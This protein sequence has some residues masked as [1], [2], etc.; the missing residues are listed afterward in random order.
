MKLCH[1]DGTSV[2]RTLDAFVDVT[3]GGLTTDGYNDF[4][5]L[6]PTSP[7][8]K[9]PTL[10]E[11]A[12]ANVQFYGRV[13]FTTGGRLALHKCAISLLRTLWRNGMRKYESTHITTHPLTIQQGI[14]QDYQEIKI[15]SPKEARRML[16]V[17]VAPDGNCDLQTK[18]LRSKSEQWS[19][20]I[21]NNRMATFEILMSY[22]QGLM[23]SLEFPLGA[24]LLTESQCK[25]IQA[26]ALTCCLQ[27]SGVLSTISRSV[28]F[29][30]KRFCGL[31]FSNL[32]T[33]AGIQK[34][35][36]LIGHIRKM[37][38]PGQIILVALACLQQEVGISTPV[39]SSSYKLYSCV[40]IPSWCN[41]VWKFLHDISGSIRYDSAWTPK[42]CFTNDTNIMEQIAQMDF[43][44]QQKYQINICRLY[45]RVYYLDE[46]M[47]SSGTNFRRDVFD[48]TKPGFHNDKFPL[49]CVPSSFTEL[50][51]SAILSIAKNRDLGTSLGLIQS[52]SSFEYCMDS[53]QQILFRFQRHKIISCHIRSA[54]ADAYHSSPSSLFFSPAPTRVAEVT[55]V[56]N[57]IHVLRS[58]EL[59]QHHI[60]PSPSINVSHPTFLQFQHYL[61]SMSSAHFRNIGLLS[62]RNWDTFLE[63]F[64]HSEIIA[65][66]D[67]SVK[68]KSGCHSY[69][70]ET[71]NELAH[72]HGRDPVDADP[73]DMTSTR[74]ERC[75]VLAILSITTA[76]A[77]LLQVQGI[78]MS[79][80][81]DNLEALK[82]LLYVIKHIQSW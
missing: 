61:D 36:L 74:A 27:K 4:T 9:Y 81:C 17:Y 51:K 53:S 40:A 18:L 15:V 31:G 1:L 71:K 25:H 57:M 6:S 11:Q 39:L 82:K 5:P 26:P 43:T 47:T 28:V 32:Y 41:C 23:K 21:R 34:L 62:V 55:I 80:Y 19:Q 30:P 72:L 7:V 38:V 59:Q 29:G 8:Q 16:G 42:A 69:L 20:R 33:E 67:A 70:I 78:E 13:L 64:R 65:V 54:Y 52:V 37:D 63:S 3:N 50:W 79:V 68:L 60:S 77:R 48:L 14:S 49:I 75:G 46:L 24:S 35:E 10:Y 58:R 22:N 12:E 56:N 2:D 45:K 76:L 73:D 66:A 44:E